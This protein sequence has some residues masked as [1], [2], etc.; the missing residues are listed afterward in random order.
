MKKEHSLGKPGPL[1]STAP[2]KD[3]V[4]HVQVRNQEEKAS[5]VPRHAT[6]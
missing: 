5:N 1:V 4:H 2:I 3:V 6:Q